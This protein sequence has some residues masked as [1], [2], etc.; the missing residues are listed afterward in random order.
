MC[1]YTGTYTDCP[2]DSSGS[3]IADPVKHNNIADKKK[4]ASNLVLT[5]MDA[6]FSLK[7]VYQTKFYIPAN[8]NPGS[9]PGFLNLQDQDLNESFFR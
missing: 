9:Y 2:D 6:S 8:K 1:E 4:K 5:A 7:F 3:A